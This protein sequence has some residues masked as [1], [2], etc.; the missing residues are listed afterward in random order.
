MSDTHERFRRM[1]IDQP[2]VRMEDIM[3]AVAKSGLGISHAYQ[4]DV[5]DDGLTPAQIEQK[6]DA[7]AERRNLEFRSLVL[8]VGLKRYA[9]LN[10][11]QDITDLIKRLAPDITL[12]GKKLDDGLATALTLLGTS[13]ENIAHPDKTEEAHYILTS[14]IKRLEKAYDTVLGPNTGLGRS[15]G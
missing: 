4:P 10:I 6:K 12:N 2:N 1:I 3:V 14:I 9:H 11:D 7:E 5:N 8:L 13:G 15:Q